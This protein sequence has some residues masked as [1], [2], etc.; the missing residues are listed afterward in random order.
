MHVIQLIFF[1]Y[2]SILF[3]LVLSYQDIFPMRRSNIALLARGFKAS[4]A[5][6]YSGKL[7]PGIQSPTSVVPPNI[8]R[9]N[10]AEDGIPKVESNRNPWEIEAQNEET[11]AKMRVAGKIAREVLDAAIRIVQ[12]G[13]T[14][15][16][17]DVLV[18]KETIQRNSYP[19]PLNYGN[20]PKSCC[21]S[22]N[23]VICH[24]IPDSTVL[25]NGDIINIDV[26]V[27]HD[28][29]HGD[30]S[31]TVLVGEV[32]QKYRDLVKTTY[33]SLQAAIAIC[34][35]GRSTVVFK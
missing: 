14:T 13:I 21:T 33:D 24:G 19:S 11:I 3:S 5:F 8:I 12:P 6:N 35:P 1:C 7:R 4:P 28:G 27:F 10:Y 29:V 34:K 20:F 23:E 25:N 32:E 26:T 15:N 2:L 18:H 22:L 31:E 17:I 30:C 9:P 16:D